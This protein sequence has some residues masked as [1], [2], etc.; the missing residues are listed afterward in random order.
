MA[1]NQIV[2][3]VIFFFNGFLIGFIFDFFRIL[4]KAFKTKDFIT[5]I[6][7]ALFWII[8]GIILIYSLFK[9]NNGEIRI[10]LFLGTILGFILYIL[11]FSK[12][13][14]KTNLFII[15]KI[16]K[17]FAFVFHL[18]AIPLKFIK[19]KLLAP[20]KVLIINIGKNVNKFTKKSLIVGKKR[21]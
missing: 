13:I 14:I 21:K 11:I 6:E 16:K 10:Y 7:D 1:L 15:I 5:Y 18:I 9:F 17:C 19:R 8:T 20:F 3:F 12:F 4:R 2:L